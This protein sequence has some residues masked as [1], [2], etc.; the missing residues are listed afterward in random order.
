MSVVTP[1]ASP[2]TEVRATAVD[3]TPL[4]RP[5]TTALRLPA[6]QL[7]LVLA[8]VVA[9]IFASL[10]LLTSFE[11]GHAQ[12]GL[13]D[14]LRSELALG[15]GPTAAPIAAGTPLAL[16]AIPAVHLSNEVV[17]EGT[18]PAALQEGPGHLRGSVLPGQA[19]V[20]VLLGRSLS[21]GHPFAH[22]ADMHPGDPIKVTTVQG[23]FTYVVQDVRGTGDVVPP[24]SAGGARLTLVTSYGSGLARSQTVYV[25]ATL[26][27]TPLAAGAVSTADPA[28]APM[29]S[30]HAAGTLAELAL[31]L[32]LVI[33]VVLG[34]GWLRLRWSG[35]GAWIAGV[36]AI[37]AALWV[38]ST[39]A[40]RLLPNLV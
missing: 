27:G 37:L 26:R 2:R 3:A 8:V 12:R 14:A 10:F 24:L 23:T 11:E 4:P 6:S 29:A 36:P 1:P 7:A 30:D 34:I 16:L 28:G 31:A 15:E 19:G 25:D 9:W 35:A 13:Y 20:S 18:T 38:V 40:W 32:Q 21:Y 5:D 39:I 17:V 22:V 33:V